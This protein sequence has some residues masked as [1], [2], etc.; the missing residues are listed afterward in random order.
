MWLESPTVAS[1]SINGRFHLRACVFVTGNGFALNRQ[2]CLPIIQ[3]GEESR[4][5]SGGCG[6]V[7]GGGGGG[8]V[9]LGGG[10]LMKR[11][12]THHWTMHIVTNLLQLWPLILLF[13]EPDVIKDSYSNMTKEKYRY[14]FV[15]ID[16]TSDL[17]VPSID[18]TQW[19]VC[20]EI[21]M[22][23]SGDVRSLGSARE[24]DGVTWYCDGW[25]MHRPGW[26]CLKSL[27]RNIER[28]SGI[29]FMFRGTS[30]VMIPFKYTFRWLSLKK[31]K[32]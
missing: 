18:E 8:V 6:G 30:T 26:C 1:C 32:C 24:Y 21:Q 19:N 14:S 31:G 17:W 28:L 11:F 27:L 4:L 29:M 9:E 25:A 3:Y 5:A 10:A 13:Q 2:Q 22:I 12:E 20:I 7:S 15:C 23:L 16:H